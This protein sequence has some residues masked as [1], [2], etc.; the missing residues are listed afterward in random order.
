[1]S[2]GSVQQGMSGRLS[3]ALAVEADLGRRQFGDGSVSF[4]TR[5]VSGC[6]NVE[7]KKSA[8]KTAIVS[9]R[10]HLFFAP[11]YTPPGK[12]GG[13]PFHYFNKPFS[14]RKWV[15][16]VDIA[17]S[18]LVLIDPDMIIT[19]VFNYHLP[20]VGEQNQV[21]KGHPVSQKYG[22][23]KYEICYISI[24]QKVHCFVT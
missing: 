10:V 2:F 18:V 19:K 7:E 15:N 21:R 4:I 8:L 16:E 22:V 24:N 13:H 20:E 11:D 3:N 23:L 12:G 14:M 1:M 5:I 17:E 9:E 6:K